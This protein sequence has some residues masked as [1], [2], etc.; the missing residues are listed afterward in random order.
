MSDA[1]KASGAWRVNP[2]SLWR[3]V[4]ALLGTRRARHNMR[5]RRLFIAKIIHLPREN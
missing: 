5:S 2:A 4:G 1:L 3:V